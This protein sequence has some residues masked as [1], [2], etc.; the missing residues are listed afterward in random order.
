[1]HPYTNQPKHAF[2]SHSITRVEPKNVDPIVQA[3]FSISKETRIST[4]GSCFAQHIARHLIASGFN[5]LITEPAPS[6]LGPDIAEEYG[7]G[8]FTAR[9]GNIY[10]SRQLVQ[11]FDRAYN[12][13]SPLDN[14]WEHTDGTYI[15]PYRPQ[16]T[17]GG[18]QSIEELR[19]DRETHFQS[20]RSMFEKS[21]VFVFTLGLTEMWIDNRDGAAY[22]V[23]PG[24][25]GG[26]FDTSKHS[27]VNLDYE[28]VV[29]DMRMFIERIRNVNPDI[30]VLLTVSPVPLVATATDQHVL[31]ATTLSK[32]V[33]RAAADRVTRDFSDVSYFPSYEIITGNFNEGRYYEDDKRGVKSIGIEHVMGL[34]FKHFCKIENT[35]K[36][37]KSKQKTTLLEEATRISQVLCDEEMLDP[38][39]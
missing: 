22:P 14:A 37:Q 9:F 3:P 11:L 4:A 31:A 10:T 35:V 39:Y 18:Y 38:S 25:S 1:M 28:D 24:T 2:W 21:D 29:S 12:E 13:F 23:C 7:Y 16:L 27:F 8:N 34:F 6:I 32:S 30:K 19:L 20:V 26:C 15:D 33:L 17:P 5:Y 36:I